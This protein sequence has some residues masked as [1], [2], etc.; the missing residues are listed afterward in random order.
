MIVAIFLAL[1]ALSVGVVY[2]AHQAPA[3]SPLHT[4]AVQ[5]DSIVIATQLPIVS[6]LVNSQAN[7]LSTSSRPKAET[8]EEAEDTSPGGSQASKAHRQ[9]TSLPSPV[10][11]AIATMQA[12]V[13]NLVKDPN[14][15]G[16]EWRGLQAKLNAATKAMARGN[17]RAAANILNGFAHQLNAMENS[18]S[19][20]QADYDALYA[21]Y[22][23]LNQQLQVTPVPRVIPNSHADEGDD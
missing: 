19:L 5:T 10:A 13:Q 12:G 2:A 3:A 1:G 7:Q 16:K 23:S 18:G 22:T 9:V 6:A 4:A 8:T 11:T 15:H 20:T 17:N 14:V 21:E